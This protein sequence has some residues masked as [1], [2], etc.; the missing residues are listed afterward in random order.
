[1]RGEPVEARMRALQIVADEEVIEN[2]LHLLDGLELALVPVAVAVSRPGGAQ[3]EARPLQRLVVRAV[4]AGEQAA[5]ERARRRLAYA[6]FGLSAIF[7][8]LAGLVLRTRA[9]SAARNSRSRACI[10]DL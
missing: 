7:L 8:L 9:L 3:C 2:G 4:L 6:G 10:C 5:R 1:M